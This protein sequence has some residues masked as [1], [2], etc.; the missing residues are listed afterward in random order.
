MFHIWPTYK[1]IDAIVTNDIESLKHW[2]TF[3]VCS[4]V[5]DEIPMPYWIYYPCISALCLQQVTGYITNELVAKG[6]HYVV[7]S[8]VPK[9]QEKIRETIHKFTQSDSQQQPQEQKSTFEW[10]KSFVVKPREHDE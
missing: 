8:L 3:W 6:H 10:L 7:N 9:A 1:S 4:S 2:T 5:L